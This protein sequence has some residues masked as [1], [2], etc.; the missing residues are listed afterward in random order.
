MEV[1]QVRVSLCVGQCDGGEAL[2]KGWHKKALI[3]FLLPP[4]LKDGKAMRTF[5]DECIFIQSGHKRYIKIM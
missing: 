2:T 1:W 3:A 4:V 5:L